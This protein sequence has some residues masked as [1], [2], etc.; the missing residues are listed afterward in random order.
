MRDEPE[1][2]YVT[3]RTSLT[4][5][6]LLGG[7]PRTFAILNAT[8]AAAIAFGLQRIALR[9]EQMP[10]IARQR[11]QPALIERQAIGKGLG[12]LASVRGRY[13]F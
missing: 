7:V 5:P 3:L 9:P 12:W 1:G 10:E 2:F 6:L 11:A 4:R 8:V 13:G